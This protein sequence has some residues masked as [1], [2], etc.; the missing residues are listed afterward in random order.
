MD[1]WLASIGLGHLIPAFREQ[2]I[3]LEQLADLTEADLRE[4]GLKIGERRRFQRAVT[5]AGRIATA[6]STA[7]VSAEHRPLTV[8]FVDLVGSTRLGE[9]LDAEDF[10]D[11]IRN[12]REFCGAAIA[13]YGGH[14]SRFIGDGILA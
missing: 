11:L 1:E 9:I 3:T 13:R 14:I 6:S 4:L 10:L 8:L 5:V 2:K 7:A 12:Y